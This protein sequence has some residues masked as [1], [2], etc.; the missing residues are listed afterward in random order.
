MLELV[1]VILVL[2]VLTSVASV[3]LNNS[4]VI[5]AA[6]Q[7]DLFVSHIRH[8]QSLAI[9]WECS[10]SLDINTTTNYRV[11]STSSDAGKPCDTAGAVIID[12]VTFQPFSRALEDSAQFSATTS[13]AFDSLGRPY[14]T[15]SGLLLSANTTIDMNAGGVTWRVTILPVSGHVS[16]ARL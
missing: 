6:H 15:G 9:N 13:V 10:L 2:G 12:P 7:A 1:I 3:K 16:L 5:T 4:G 14:N 8:L 11:T